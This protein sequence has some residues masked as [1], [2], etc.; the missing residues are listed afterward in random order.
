MKR[1]VIYK[2]ILVVGILCSAVIMSAC[3]G[4]DSY[5]Q[6]LKSGYQKYQTGQ[7]MT[8]EEYNAVKSFNDWKYKNS[9]HTYNDWNN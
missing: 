3:G 5:E 6:T 8:R 2:A 1:N 4:S 9:S 7:Q